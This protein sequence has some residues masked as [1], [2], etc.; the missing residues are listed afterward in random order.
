M[1]L[2]SIVIT[3][4]PAAIIDKH[5]QRHHRAD[6]TRRKQN[7][8]SHFASARQD[9]GCLGPCPTRR[10]RLPLMYTSASPLHRHSMLVPWA[11]AHPRHTTGIQDRSLE[12]SIRCSELRVPSLRVRVHM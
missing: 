6:S 11:H 3:G 4:I 10:L 9:E 5:D 7:L 12:Y 2:V 1:V 8:V